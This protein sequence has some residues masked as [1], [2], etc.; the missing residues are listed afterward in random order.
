MYNDGAELVL[1]EIF[2]GAGQGIGGHFLVV[3]FGD[4]Y[5]LLLINLS[6]VVV[7]GLAVDPKVT[8]TGFGAGMGLGA[9]LTTRQQQSTGKGCR[10]I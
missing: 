4:L 6:W 9:I 3:P 1:H 7:R 5:E 2:Q 10:S 8:G